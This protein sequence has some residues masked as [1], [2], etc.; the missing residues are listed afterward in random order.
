MEP[1]L[2][3][4][5][6]SS[7]PNP[8][9]SAPAGEPTTHSDS[10]KKWGHWALFGSG[11]LVVCYCLAVLGFVATGPDIGLRCLLVNDEADGPASGLDIKQIIGSSQL[12]RCPRPSPGDRLTEIE[13]KP[14]V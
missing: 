7:A 6:R 5:N 1:I 10:W 3:A 8:S 12:D 2:G 4:E 14:A 11:G 13:R 9:T